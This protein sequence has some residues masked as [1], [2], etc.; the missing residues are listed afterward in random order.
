MKTLALQGG[1]GNQLFQVFTLISYAMDNNDQFFFEDKDIKRYG[2]N[3]NYFDTI[4]HG[5]K[6]YRKKDTIKYMYK[7]KSLKYERIPPIQDIKLYGYFQSYKYFENNFKRIHDLLKIDTLRGKYKDK[8]DYD[9]TVSLHFRIGDYKDIQTYHPVLVIDYYIDSL[10]K[11]IKDTE[12]DNWKILYFYEKNDEDI[13]Q[14]NIKLLR[15]IFSNLVFIPIKHDLHDWEQLLCM[16]LCRHNIIANSSFSWWGA[17]LNNYDNIVYYPGEW[18]GPAMIKEDSS[19]KICKDLLP[20]GW[21]KININISLSGYYINLKYRDDRKKHMIKNVLN[22]DFFKKISRFD[23]IKHNNGSLGCSLSHINVLAQLR[24]SSERYFLILED[25]FEIANENIM[26]NFERDLDDFLLSEVDWDIINLTSYRTKVKRDTK[27]IHNFLKTEWTQTTSGYIINR[28]SLDKLI[29]LWIQSVEAFQK[30]KDMKKTIEDY[31][32]DQKWN[33]LENIY[34]YNSIFA[35][36]LL[37][38]SDITN[39]DISAP[40]NLR[41]R[42]YRLVTHK[43]TYI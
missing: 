17:Y 42:E 41:D 25:D 39:R 26:N 37:D 34:V 19:K 2:E 13:I 43:I 11:L 23:A 4:L 16:S 28:Y 15:E 24:E 35:G 27:P 33:E 32:I 8:Y 7:E 9:K 14:K 12:K 31:S 10:N 40:E 20:N 3:A 36:Q 30:S 5:L 18:F 29:N 6:I 38:Y 1:L 22:K 21:N